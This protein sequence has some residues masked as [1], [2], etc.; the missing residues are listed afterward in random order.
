MYNKT[1]RV[2]SGTLHRWLRTSSACL[3]C[4]RCVHPYFPR[5]WHTD[6]SS[7]ILWSSPGETETFAQSL[8]NW[9]SD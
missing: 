3:L 6:P 5:Q 2:L 8:Q 9:T 4:A 1:P 7:T